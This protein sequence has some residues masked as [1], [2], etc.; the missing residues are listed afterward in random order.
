LV[1]NDA[2]EFGKDD[3]NLEFQLGC[4]ELL[5]QRL[6]QLSFGA[7]IGAYERIQPMRKRGWYRVVSLI[8]VH[9]ALAIPGM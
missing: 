3:C 9:E 5:G 7:N 4:L 2:S 8:E 1:D 6:W